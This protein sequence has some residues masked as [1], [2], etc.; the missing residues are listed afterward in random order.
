MGYPQADEYSGG[1]EDP[2]QKNSGKSSV[3]PCIDWSIVNATMF[4]RPAVVRKWGESRALDSFRVVT[5]SLP[6]YNNGELA[7]LEDKY[8]EFGGNFSVVSVHLCI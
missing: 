4:T 6:L 7:F 3:N 1:I 8:Y 2:L 5:E